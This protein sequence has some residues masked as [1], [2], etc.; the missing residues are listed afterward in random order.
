M[1]WRSLL[2][3]LG[4]RA[5]SVNFYLSLLCQF[6]VE[7]ICL[8]ISQRLGGLSQLLVPGEEMRILAGEGGIQKSN[9]ETQEKADIQILSSEEEDSPAPGC[10]VCPTH[11]GS[12][13]NAQASCWTILSS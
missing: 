11:T 8:S 9:I 2:G 7:A 4:D 10:A 6:E 5:V 3:N 12:F 1:Q 13:K